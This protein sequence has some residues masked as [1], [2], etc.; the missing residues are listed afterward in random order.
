MTE[1]QDQSRKVR[2]AGIMV[3]LLMAAVGFGIGTAQ[4]GKKKAEGPP[5]DLPGHVA[6]LGKQ[7]YGLDVEDAEP[8]TNEIQKLVVGHLN[9][10]IANRSPNII[11]V[12]HELDQVFSKLQY[13]AIGTPSV[14]KAPWKGT[15]LIG[16][17]Y[18]LGWSDIWR[19]NVVVLYE[20]RNG[21]TREVA[22]TQ[23]VPRTDL[24]YAILSP[25]AAG[26]FRFLAYGWKLGMSHPRL[27]VLL[28]SFDGKKLQSQWKTEDLFGGKLTVTN[29]VLVIRYLNENEY[30]RETQQGHLPPRHQMTYKITPQGLQLE[31]E[32]DIPY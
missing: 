2:W 14:F 4:A 7:L 3:S 11:Q 21:Q 6:Y 9:A 15:E 19:V 32:H 16:A 8:V 10:W 29:N 5:V 26:D 30:V 12:R 31:S 24:H 1:Q 27:T 28:Y 13:P 20:T 17:G 18:T 22:T 25:S 23:F